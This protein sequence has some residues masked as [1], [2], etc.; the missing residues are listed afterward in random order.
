MFSVC[1]S[2]SSFVLQQRS[3]EGIGCRPEQ[4]R[5]REFTLPSLILM[6]LC[7]APSILCQHVSHTARHSKMSVVRL[8]V[9]SHYP[10]V[11]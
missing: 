8:K 11:Q 10:P 5:F 2:E 6:I 1:V 7:A 3:Q 4:N 9:R